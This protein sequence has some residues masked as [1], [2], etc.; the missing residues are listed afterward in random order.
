MAGKN[1]RWK[2]GCNVREKGSPTAEPQ[3]TECRLAKSE[4]GSPF[5]FVLRNSE[6]DIRQ[7]AVPPLESI[8]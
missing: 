8:L 2:A 3:N 6:I 7:F 4:V 5:F 1:S